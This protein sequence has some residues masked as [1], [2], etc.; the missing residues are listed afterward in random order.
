MFIFLAQ[1]PLTTDINVLE[2]C[3]QSQKLYELSFI[4]ELENGETVWSLFPTK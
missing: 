2:K 1:A 4:I 3:I